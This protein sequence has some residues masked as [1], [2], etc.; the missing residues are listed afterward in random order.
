MSLSSKKKSSEC[1][2]LSEQE[3]QDFLD[4]ISSDKTIR[5]FALF[6]LHTGCRIGEAAAVRFKDID[7]K[8]NLVNI[9]SH[10]HWER[11]K[12]GKTTLLPGTKGITDRTIPL[13]PECAA[14]LKIRYGVEV[15][16]IRRVRG[17]NIGVFKRNTIRHSRRSE[18]SK[19]SLMR[20]AIRLR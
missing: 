12:G 5:D 16:M 18:L 11:T 2:F 19:K 3:E 8:R 13:T 15:S 6:Q 4:A 10:L 1:R 20:F 14:M 17:C 7:F 9:R